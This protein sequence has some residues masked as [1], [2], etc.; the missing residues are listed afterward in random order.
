[1]NYL[2]DLYNEQEEKHFIKI[3]NNETG[4]GRGDIVEYLGIKIRNKGGKMRKNEE[5]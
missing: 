2:R 4:G 3:A 5:K 1:L